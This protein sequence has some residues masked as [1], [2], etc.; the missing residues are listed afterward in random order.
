VPAAAAATS[1]ATGADRDIRSG[2]STR[3]LTGADSTAFVVEN[4]AAALDMI[5]IKSSLDC[6]AR[7]SS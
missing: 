5:A 3:H 2:E 7:R 1:L 4:A 6:D